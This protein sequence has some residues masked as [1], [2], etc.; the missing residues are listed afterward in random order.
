MVRRFAG[1]SHSVHLRSSLSVGA[2]RW[3]HVDAGMRVYAPLCPVISAIQ[4]ISKVLVCH[5]MPATQSGL[6]TSQTRNKKFTLR[7]QSLNFIKQFRIIRTL[8]I[9]KRPVRKRYLG[10]DI[11]GFRAIEHWDKKL[12]FQSLD[13]LCKPFLFL[14]WG[15]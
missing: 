7:F 6:N 14:G 13:F 10:Y 1:R 5:T 15:V 4:R 8:S 3:R 11:W 12:G 2:M 9:W